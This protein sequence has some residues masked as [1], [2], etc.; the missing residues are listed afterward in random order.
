[1]TPLFQTR[2]KKISNVH[3]VTWGQKSHLYE[4]HIKVQ[5]VERDVSYLFKPNIGSHRCQDRLRNSSL[6]WDVRPLRKVE[7][8]T[9]TL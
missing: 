7:L 6:M 8:G 3:A 1:M 5:D 4:Q 2:I 9:E